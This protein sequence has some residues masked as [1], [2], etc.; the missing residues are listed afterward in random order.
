MCA[1]IQD[2][3]TSPTYLIKCC[4]GFDLN[5]LTSE[6]NRLSTHIFFSLLGKVVQS[7]KETLQNLNDTY[8]AP[9]STD[10]SDHERAVL[11]YVAGATIHTVTKD[12]QHSASEDMIDNIHQAK[13]EYRCFQLLQSLH[14]P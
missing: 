7:E 12:L 3:L 1:V 13:I 8:S 9:I 2:Y 6:H 11:R 14:I 4:K 10:M 5:T